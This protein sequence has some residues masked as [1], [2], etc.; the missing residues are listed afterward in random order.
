MG[1]VRAI[2]GAPWFG[3]GV[4]AVVLA[5]GCAPDLAIGATTG[6]SSGGG[7]GGGASSMVGGGGA[8]GADGG[9]GSGGTS[10]T[11]TGGGGTGGSGG[12]PASG[13][14]RWAERIPVAG[15]QVGT[16]IAVD[17]QG[18]ARTSFD[19]VTDGASLV[20]AGVFTFV[21][22]PGGGYVEENT[23][24][25]QGD[26]PHSSRAVAIDPSDNVVVVG[27]LF[28]TTEDDVNDPMFAVSAGGSDCLVVK[29]KLGLTWA[30]ALGGTGFSECVGVVIGASAEIFVAGTFSGA[31]DAEGM[32]VTSEG[33][34]DVFV[35]RY[36]TNGALLETW[37]Y[38]DEYRQSARAAG[39]DAAGNVYVLAEEEGEGIN[40]GADIVLLKLDPSTG[41]M[42]PRHFPNPGYERA[43]ALWVGPDGSFAMAGG[44]NGSVDLGGE[45]LGHDTLNERRFV[46]RFDANG[47][48]LMSRGLFSDDTLEVPGLVVD[49]EGNTFVGGTFNYT[50]ELDGESHSSGGGSTDAF[51]VKLG[52][53]GDVVWLR[54]LKGPLA[55]GIGAMALTPGGNLAVAGHTA[56]LSDL[57]GWSIYASDEGDHFALEMVP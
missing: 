20:S 2:V 50:F 38:G 26:G 43:M 49:A 21:D 41:T 13:T 56:E 47:G 7:G 29:G 25:L 35:A 12:G 57:D 3:G 10:G 55:D 8:G 31:M 32:P 24:F 9:G 19:T 34:E 5:A 37:T 1:G 15:S 11:T 36:S 48:H 22:E 6:E 4:V 44:F 28:G 46:A 54:E 18:R 33:G 14:V 42:T 52:P 40:G 45:V 17:S 51:V 23:T 30:R 39:R 16:G 53:A 27:A